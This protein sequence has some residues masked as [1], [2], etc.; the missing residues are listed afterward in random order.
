LESTRARYQLQ[1]QSSKFKV[2]SELK[3]WKVERGRNLPPSN[4]TLN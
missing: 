1:V 3:S 2:Q 4:F